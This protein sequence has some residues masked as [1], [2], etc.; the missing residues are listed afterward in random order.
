MLYGF[1]EFMESRLFFLPQ[2][3]CGAVVFQVQDGV[4][5]LLGFDS[6]RF[7]RA[8]VSQPIIYRELAAIDHA[9]K[10]F[11]YAILNQHLHVFTDNMSLAHVFNNPDKSNLNRRVLY[12]LNRLSEYTISLRHTPGALNLAADC[13]SR[14]VYPEFDP[15]PLVS[16]ELLYQHQSTNLVLLTTAELSLDPF[17]QRVRAAYA[18]DPWVTTIIN[19][20]SDESHPLAS[21]YRMDSDGT[22]LLCIPP[23][24][25]SRIVIPTDK[26][27]RLEVLA[28]A[29]DVPM[30]GHG[31]K[32]R[33][34]A[35]LSDRYYWKRMLLD[36]A[37]YVA[38]CAP[39]AQAKSTQ[40]PNHLIHPPEI[41]SAPWS[42][43]EIDT[44]SGLSVSHG[45]DC[46]LCITDRF[47]RCVLFLATRKSATATQLGQLLFE[48]MCIRSHVGI[49]L[50]VSSDRAKTFTAALM[51]SF[52]QTLGCRI[53]YACVNTPQSQGQVE[54]N[55][56]GLAT[57]IRTFTNDHA[58]DWAPLLPL[59]AFAKNSSIH[60]ATNTTPYQ[61]WF[62][63][64]PRSLLDLPASSEDR[65][66]AA[67]VHN[68]N[69]KYFRNLAAASINDSQDSS[70]MMHSSSARPVD[71]R[72]GDRVWVHRDILLPSQLRHQGGY[73]TLVK[74]H[75]PF[76]V[77]AQPA[78]NA[79]T[80]DWPANFRGHHTV[81]IRHL[82]KHIVVPHLSRPQQVRQPALLDGAEMFLVKRILAH[83]FDTK[84]HLEFK[85][86]WE[87]FPPSSNS[88]QP[89]H[90]FIENGVIVNQHLLSYIHTHN[91]DIDPLR[92]LLS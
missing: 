37:A 24:S 8:L 25:S 86:A 40:R 47:S 30:S 88:Y 33:T 53:S 79:F 61:A 69:L 92:P 44:F 31:D 81:N 50:H 34:Y 36:V 74:Y 75:G 38:S 39:C 58:S 1:I 18:A 57:Y 49:P 87:G 89:L 11:R 7:P 68:D 91:L 73:K 21:K 76:R 28:L 60:A 64:T 52:L 82:K 27:L 42:H 48:H 72:V 9:I 63:Y 16:A 45:Y 41:P 5:K 20:I 23:L 4:C 67:S 83:R 2:N 78:P 15:A 12:T 22:L 3:A 17:L 55:N 10:S 84:G 29:H 59:A 66:P 26:A 6:Q 54:R 51:R 32:R 19:S 65:D 71:I 13:L 80:L 77:M 70:I 85:V 62:G 56:Q 35:R 43:I 46:I 14:T 90:D